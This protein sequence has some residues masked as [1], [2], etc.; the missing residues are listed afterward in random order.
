VGL[1]GCG[2]GGGSS[3]SA[4][5]SATAASTTGA[6]TTAASTTGTSGQTTPPAG[7]VPIG[8]GLDGPRGLTATVYAKGPPTVA[9]FAYDGRGRLWLVAAGLEAHTHD[10]VYVIAGPGDPPQQVVSGLNDPLGLDWY[11][12]RLYV[13]SVGRVDAY[14]GFDG[15]RFTGHRLIVNGPLSEGENNL[16]VTAPDGRMVMGVSA[17]CD[18]CQPTSEWDGAIVSFRPD[19]SNLRLYATRIRAPVGLAYV[20]GTGDLLVSMNQRDDLGA[21]TPGDWLALVREGQSWGFPGCYG[22]S[23]AACAGVPK[24]LAEL[25]KHG[26]VGPI[27]VVTGQL[28]PAVGTA[29]LV[30]EWNVAKV[31]RVA[32]AKVGGAYA[33]TVHPFLAGIKNPL[34]LALAPDGSLLVGDWSTGT[35]YRV[36]GDERSP[37][38]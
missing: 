31:Q 15:N 35:I 13:A 33:G 2:S 12:G 16:L 8:A 29:A 23:G 37:H 21:A 5:A 3:V 10:G 17:T 14:W 27:A 19:G 1:A 9:T 24:Q 6:S 30:S 34:A 11:A 28:G 7:L 20:P 25:D 38:S 36:R 22:Q 32:L 26:A 18:H 4:S